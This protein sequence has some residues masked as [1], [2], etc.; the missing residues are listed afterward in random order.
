M[1]NQFDEKGKIFTYVISKIPVRV[2]IQTKTHKIRGE[3]YV[4]RDARIKD[5][6][7]QSEHFLAVTNAVVLGNEDQPLHQTKF[8]ILNLDQIIWLIPDDEALPG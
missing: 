6:L 7:D 3:V 8:L 2:T 1:S 5:E 4:R